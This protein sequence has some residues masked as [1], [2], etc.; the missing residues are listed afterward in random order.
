MPKLVD[1]T[2]ISMGFRRRKLS[3]SSSD[4]LKTAPV[5][6]APEWRSDRRGT[7]GISA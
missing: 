3:T 5:G 4:P 7:G 2:S 1:R 6:M